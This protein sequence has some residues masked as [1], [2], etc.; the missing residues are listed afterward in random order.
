MLKKSSILTPTGVRLSGHEKANKCFP[1][2]SLLVR[3]IL[4]PKI[5]NLRATRKFTRSLPLWPQN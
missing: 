1:S 4:R 5:S 2:L 3:I